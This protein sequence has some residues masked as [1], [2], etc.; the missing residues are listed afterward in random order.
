MSNLRISNIEGEL[1][2]FSAN[3]CVRIAASDAP[4]RQKAN[5]DYVC[6]GENDEI[7]IQQAVTKLCEEG[8]GKL[9]LSKGTFYVDS[10]QNLDGDGTSNVA[11]LIPS[12]S[13]PHEIKIIGDSLPYGDGVGTSFY[14]RDSVYD[15]LLPNIQY[16]IIGFEY[17][18]N[19]VGNAKSS[20]MMTDIRFS[21]PWNQ[22]MIMCI[23]LF[24]CN[25]VQLERIQCRAYRNGYQGGWDV[26]LKVPPAKAIQGCIGIRFTGGSN[27]GT[28]CDYRNISVA[29]FYEGFQVGGEHVIGINLS[30]IF[31]VY[32]YTFGNY[33][34]E[35][36]FNHPITLINCCDE[37]NVNLP[38]FAYN[39]EG[40]NNSGQQVTLIDF[41]I[42]RIAAYTP[43]KTLGNLMKEL[44]PG[45]FYGGVEYTIQ[46]QYGGQANSVSAKLWE[47][48][49][50]KNFISRNALHKRAC[51][52]TTRN[53]YAPTYLQRIWDTTLNK[54]VICT[55]TKN[56]TWVDSN[57]NVV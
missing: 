20:L 31:C 49:H 12:N 10:F 30:A 21:I 54:E 27:A 37:R 52:T 16:K 40:R 2:A 50:G 38:L 11:I 18:Q 28:C 42:E 35:N 44:T 41:N 19:L 15:S 13:N 8:G 39:G 48:G 25:R 7:V 43:G 9:L 33:N 24:S 17:R 22:K 6:S 32:G 56:K 26:S 34:W 4:K 45:T 3:N 1:F 5:A 23:D 55:D 53:S 14:I 47:D 57:G 51:D 46:T 29:G 36:G